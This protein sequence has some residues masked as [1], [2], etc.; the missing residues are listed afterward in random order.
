MTRWEPGQPVHT[1]Q[2]HADWLAWRTERKRQQQRYRRAR[3]RRFDYHASPDTAA[4]LERLWKPLAGHDYS[5]IIDRIVRDW[6][7]DCHRNKVT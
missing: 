2:D 4:T 5:T 1:A 3:L 6:L 7:H